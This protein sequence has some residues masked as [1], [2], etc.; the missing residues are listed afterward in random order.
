M[1]TERGELYLWHPDSN[2][3]SE[4]RWCIREANSDRILSFGLALEEAEEAIK[5]GHSPDH[6]TTTTYR[7]RTGVGIIEGLGRY[8][9]RATLTYQRE[10]ITATLTWP[11]GTTG[12]SFNRCQHWL[13]QAATRHQLTP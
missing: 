1:S 2:D 4:P 7:H 13:E 12:T 9:C 11:A 8:G 5:S 6:T 3:T 10:G